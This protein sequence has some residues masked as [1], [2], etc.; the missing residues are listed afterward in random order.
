MTPPTPRDL[1]PPSLRDSNLPW[2]ARHDDQAPAPRLHDGWA[3]RVGHLL[4]VLEV[5]DGPSFS[6]ALSRPPVELASLE[7]DDLQSA[8]TCADAILELLS[9]ST[10]QRRPFLLKL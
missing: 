2:T 4:L 7:F 8:S 6:L 5:E 1:L 10:V 3:A 9:S